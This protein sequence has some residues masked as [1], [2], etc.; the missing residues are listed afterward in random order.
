MTSNADDHFKQHRCIEAAKLYEDAA[1]STK[2]VSNKIE[3]YKKAAAA[4]DEYGSYDEE[5]RCL[6][7][8]CSLLRGEDKVDCLV[9][10]WKAY[11]K[12]IAVFQY[13]TGFEWKGEIENLNPS[14]GETIENYYKKAVNVLEKALTVQGVNK[15]RL[16]DKLNAECEKRQGEGGWAAS[17]CFSSVKEAL[18]R[19]SSI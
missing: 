1:Q 4:Y 7:L 11:I 12:A 5:V 2:E 14:Y 13:D 9:L 18:R 8:A 6:M 10:C 15:S 19:N 16:L 17:E 3:L